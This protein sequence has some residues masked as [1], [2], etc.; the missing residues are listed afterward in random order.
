MTT[1][2]IHCTLIKNS[3]YLASLLKFVLNTITSMMR[4]LFGYNNVLKV[5]C[6]TGT[7]AFNAFGETLHQLTCQGIGSKYKP[8]TMSDSKKELLTN[9]YKHLLRLIIDKQSLLTS[10][11]LGTTAQII[12][13]T[14]FLWL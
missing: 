4:S 1:V 9:R 8:N 11:L 7:L 14:I 12:S 10:W 13:E 5:G 6:P 2:F 3:F